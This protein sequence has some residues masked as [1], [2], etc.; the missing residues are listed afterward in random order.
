MV[1]LRIV[2]RPTT[3][4]NAPNKTRSIVVD[5]FQRVE[6][7]VN[8][9]KL[10]KKGTHF[11]SISRGASSREL[12]MNSSL[13]SHNIQDGQ[14]IESCACPA[15]SAVLSAVLRDLDAVDQLEDDQRDEAHIRPLLDL[16]LDLDTH[17]N[18][19]SQL[20]LDPWPTRWSREELKT[21]K[22]C[23]ATYKKVIQRGERFEDTQ[24]P[25]GLGHDLAALCAFMKP[26]LERESLS[27]SSNRT[28]NRSHNSL[29][30]VIKPTS[31]NGNGKP[32]TC[33]TL[34]QNKLD[35][36][37]RIGETIGPTQDA[38]EEF[39][40]QDYAR[41]HGSAITTGTPRSASR[42]TRVNGNTPT[43]NTTWT[44]QRR[45][46][47]KLHLPASTPS[48]AAGTPTSGVGCSTCNAPSNS[49]CL[50]E[51]CPFWKLFSCAACFRGNHPLL[52]RDHE[53]VAL[54][55]ARVRPILRMETR[56]PYVPEYASGAYAILSTLVEAADNEKQR[57][58]SLDESRLKTLAQQRCRSNLYD[59][60][61]R[62]RNAFSCVENLS[63]KELI[64][65]ELIPGPA[66]Q[67]AKF[68]L[69]AP[70]EA[71]GRCCL[72]FEKALNSTLTTRE[73]T[74]ARQESL[75]GG[76]TTASTA[77]TAGEGV[78]LIIDTREDSTYAE[79]L[80]GRCRDKSVD[81]DRRDLPA[82]D[83][84]YTFEVDGKEMV[85][86]VVIERKSWS[87]LADSVTGRGH[88]RLDC[89]R[90]DGNGGSTC[91]GNCQL[92]RM[93]K[94]GC[95]TIL[96]LIEGARCLNRDHEEK[97]TDSMRCKYCRE[98]VERHG[99][100]VVH[101]ELEKVLFKLQAEHGCFI[102]FTRGYN[103]TISSLLMIRSI[104]GSRFDVQGQTRT[105]ARGALKNLSTYQQFCTNA[106][107]STGPT[108]A[109]ATNGEIVK[110]TADE[111][112]SEINTGK[113]RRLLLQAN[114]N[115]G[116]PKDPKDDTIIIDY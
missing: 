64:R 15:L 19:E 31:K 26:V 62:G 37:R 38:I 94:S 5:T 47:R 12:P 17:D 41:H 73:M 24:V 78:R 80:A 91:R 59:R 70:G 45:V 87:D 20:L 90:L 108:T 52:Q 51:A 68:S 103:E 96:F 84:L 66:S 65:K 86:P 11:Y 48:S 93:K 2:V 60:Q 101:E 23:L 27:S 39:V 74:Q 36:L 55:D 95:S 104:L 21:R 113:V 6:D 114:K 63:D 82:G 72:A 29:L 85:L 67:E 76:R 116:T 4:Y 18:D 1:Q 30:H 57:E 25:S 34:L 88:R 7:V 46:R 10:E 97:C 109:D 49:I 22:I 107:R 69:L 53:R 92:C 83:Y 89:V 32:T 43:S 56:G 111:F 77:S 28:A 105:V 3:A 112:I 102:H 98:L 50:Q 44:P 35:K 40:K 115:T 54:T 14:V 81:Y 58:F 13:A 16:D 100:K 110:W 71:L 33:W 8:L 61:A 75:H 79:R 106:R 99:S 9:L 42:R